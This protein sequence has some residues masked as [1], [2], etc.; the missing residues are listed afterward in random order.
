MV[1]PVVGLKDAALKVSEGELGTRVNPDGP[2]EVRDLSRAF[3]F[4]STRLQRNQSELEENRAAI[5]AFNLELQNQL[6]AQALQL[7]DA[8]RRLVQ[9]AR[10][11]AVGQMGAGL[12]HELNNPLAGILGLVQLLQSK[13]GEHAPMLKNIEEQA[14]RCSEI[15]AH[16]LRFSRGERPTGPVDQRDWAVVDL[17]EVVSEV[18]TLMAGA[19]KEVGV[20]LRHTTCDGLNVR[21]DR[22]AIGTAVAQLMTSLRAACLESGSIAIEGKRTGE[23]VVYRLTV[24][25]DALN[26]STDAWMATG[27]GF[28]FARQVLAA[29]GGEMKEP[30]GT[31]SDKI[32]RWSF[33][34]P[35]AE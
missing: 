6:E 16:L 8:N 11:A 33:H 5:A 14:R 17:D 26:L 19:S 24:E 1:L 28:W 20:T 10:L 29:H 32:A 13:G 34:L 3:N 18:I 30:E 21:C 7:N 35:A 31:L 27:M 23:H 9:T 15:V 2:E 22:E 12:A 25:G 4:M